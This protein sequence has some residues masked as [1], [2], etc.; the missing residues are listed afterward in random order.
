MLTRKELMIKKSDAFINLPGGFG[1]LD[2][3]F[4][5]ITLKVL[6]QLDDKPIIIVNHNRYWDTLLKFCDEIIEKKFARSHA[7]DC[8]TV[9]DTL[10]EAFKVLGV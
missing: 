5:V 6:Q 4:E 3:L 7:R 2:E 9:V 1:T 10:E 8:Y